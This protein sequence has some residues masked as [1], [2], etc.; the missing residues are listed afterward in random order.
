MLTRA[1]TRYPH[2]VR[3]LAA[4]HLAFRY[5]ILWGLCFSGA[6]PFGVA[7]ASLAT[8]GGSLDVT[9]SALEDEGP[10]PTPGRAGLGCTLR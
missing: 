8:K 5:S 10:H 7:L 3:P 6:A 1:E 2:P 4:G 9:L